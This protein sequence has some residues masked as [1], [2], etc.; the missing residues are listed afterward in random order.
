MSQA[1]SIED[2]RIELDFEN[3][4]RQLASMEWHE[5]KEACRYAYLQG[6]GAGKNEGLRMFAAIEYAKQTQKERL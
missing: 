3:V 4:W 2:K 5:L 6:R 1:V